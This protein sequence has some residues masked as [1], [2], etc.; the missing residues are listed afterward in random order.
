MRSTAAL[1][2]RPAEL[3]TRPALSSDLVADVAIVGGGITGL[4]CAVFLAEAGKRV[5]LLEGRQLGAGVTGRTTAHLTE[6]VDIRYHRLE[7]TLGDEAARLVRA[8]S[9]QAIETIASLSSKV[10]CGF[11]RIN[12]Y[13][14]TEHERQMS[15]LD[16]E[17]LAAE[18]AGAQVSR[19][20]VP[21]PFSVRAGICFEDQAQI[22][23]LS[24]VL[25]LSQRLRKTSAQIFE[26]TPVLDVDGSSG[27]FRVSTE[28]GHTVTADWVVMATHAYFGKLAVQ[29]KLAQYRSYA[30][31]GPAT[32]THAG[33]FWDMD[34]P[35]HYVRRA[36]VDAQPFVIV[37]GADH[38]TGVV[39]EDGADAPYRELEG[40][41]ARLGMKPT[42]R[43]SAQVVES[44][45]GLPLIGPIEQDGRLLIATG[46]GGNGMTF[47]TVAARLLADAVL[48]SN[49]PYASLFR[50]RRAHVLASAT[51]VVSENAETAA[52]LV[53]GH[54][55]PVSHAPLSELA[56]GDG[57]VVQHGKEKLAVYRDDAGEL[58]RV[59]A[60]C[61]H[62]GCQVAFNAVERSWDCPCH[63]SRF[64]VDGAV[65]NGPATQ[66][67]ATVTDSSAT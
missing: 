11:Q 1:W 20:Q 66:P 65:L 34:D 3:E 9:R 36:F 38:R 47:G 15:E 48:G 18:R 22:E 33:L 62:Q 6:A 53:A 64:D 44:A 41:A 30:L 43:W 54:L 8:A 12:G 4:T 28:R 57:R 49:N 60:T 24:Y 51:A 25:A 31:A 45:D 61:T 14:F 50:P 42:L 10:E 32:A 40:Y 23:P 29:L 67:L 55:K 46:Y 16:A 7:S 19:S 37:G 59:S 58:H 26:A 17:L 21:L 39:P 63:G 2:R 5:V 52:H 27:A 35:Y 56:P 13:L